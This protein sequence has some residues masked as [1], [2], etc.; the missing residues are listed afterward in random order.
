VKITCLELICGCLLLS[1][2][3]AAAAVRYVDLNNTAPASPYTNWTAAATNIQQA[4][5]VSSAGDEILVTNGVYEV[6]GQALASDYTNRIA[7]T[8]PV[9][10]RSVNGPSV[11]SIRGVPGIS[12]NGARC[13]YLVG[14]ATLSGFT[15]T[16]GGTRNKVWWMPYSTYVGGGVYCESASAVLT[17]C[18]ILGNAADESAGGVYSGT[19]I[20]CELSGN[21]AGYHGAGAFRSSLTRCR[22]NSNQSWNW[23]GGAEACSLDACSLSNN[24]AGL[25]GGGAFQSTL[26]N[27]TV[28]NN[29]GWWG[30]GVN[31][32]TL[33]NC[34]VVGN[35]GWEGG[36]AHGCTLINSAVLGNSAGSIGGGAV[37][38]SLVNCALTGNS[39]GGSGGGAYE[40]ALENCIVY[41]NSAPAGSNYVGGALNW[42]CTSPLP[43]AGTNNFTTDP[44]L[45]DSFHLAANSLCLDAGNT[46]SASGVD[47]DGHAWLNPPA[48]GCDQFY[49]GTATGALSIA[50]QASYT[51]AAAGFMVSLA[52]N[53]VGHAAASRWDFGDGTI[54]SNRPW[55]AHT[56]D[57]S[58]DYAVVFTAFNDTFPAGVSASLTVHAQPQIHYVS[59]DSTNPVA[60]YAAWASAA[61]NIEDAVDAAFVGSTVLVS[62]GVYAVGGRVVGSSTT[63]RLVVPSHVSVESLHGPTV[64]AI[65]G[66]QVPGTTNGESAV[67]CVWLAADASLT[68]FTLTKGATA[69]AFTG[70]GPP[71]DRTGGGAFFGE[72]A[73]ATLSGCMLV[74]NA[75]AYYGGAAV[76]G[77]L[78]NCLL[79]GNW[80][81]D[82]GGGAC[83]SVLNNCTLADNRA[84]GSGG[85][86]ADGALNNC[87]VISNTAPDGPDHANCALSFCCTPAASDGPGNITN[88]P[89]FVDQAAGNYHLQASSPCISS[90]RNA[91]AP[92]PAD[93]DGA[94]RTVN[95]T[96]DIGAL[97]FQG[98]GSRVSYAWLQQFGLPTDGTV[99]FADADGDHHNTWQEWR[100]DT[101]PT[102]ALSVLRL[103]A[104]TTA[105]GSADA[106]WQSV[107]NRTYF[108][109]RATN[110]VGPSMFVTV[111]TNIAGQSGTTTYTD[112]SVP[113]ATRL[114]YR[115]GIQE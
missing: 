112:T 18:L 55:A 73:T 81:G 69:V 40:S 72:N 9:T 68:G 110:L 67:R 92:G 59:L 62:N 102:N 43:G 39:A 28:A 98:T 113:D 83:W 23:G 85:G 16:D 71:A 54:L 46:A 41:F 34:T 31:G 56:W 38:G 82:R 109:E 27:C 35:S 70:E 101:V 97:E 36:G 45:A 30:A 48:V 104:V 10:V 88:A 47:I 90:G 51:N 75:A 37:G 26:N 80:S 108:L 89:L 44:Q 17:N 84:S 15:L 22:L 32:C 74:G 103:M 76:N 60:P 5:D 1:C 111:A 13:A 105:P 95:G 93:L 91:D 87:I 12:A 86:G 50:M 57:T 25:S 21:Y 24:H 65:E 114:F 6:G 33:N 106:T 63:N 96:V 3:E 42:C 77:T 4:I 66:Y 58:G 107:P 64:T 8:R 53:I 115:V 19:L 52:A 94:A 100:A 78:D 61:T 20:D 11:T 2:L 49:S 14:G 99:D 7:V 79:T 29:S